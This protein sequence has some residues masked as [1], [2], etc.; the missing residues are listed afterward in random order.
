MSGSTRD[1]YDRQVARLVLESKP[2]LV[3]LAGWMHILSPT[4]LE[5]IQ[6]GHQAAAADA[7]L[8]PSPTE[9]FPCVITNPTEV[10][11]YPPRLPIPIINLHP[12]LPGAFDG[13][14]AIGRAYEA[15]QRGE[16]KGTGV[17]V[18]EVVA[19]VDQG[20]PL[21]VKQ[22]DIKATDSL[23]DLENRIHEVEHGIIVQGARIVLDGLSRTSSS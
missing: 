12:A 3:V 15:F 13:A 19:E 8:P 23:E 4:F 20:Q 2:D 22:V 9:S 5:M 6:G 16:I 1:D 11:T 10:P 21:V 7:Q 14:N 18:H 17:M